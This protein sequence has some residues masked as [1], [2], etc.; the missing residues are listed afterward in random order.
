MIGLTAKLIGNAKG[1]DNRGLSFWLKPFLLQFNFGDG[2]DFAGNRSRYVYLD[3]FFFFEAIDELFGLGIAG[4]IKFVDLFVVGKHAVA[5]LNTLRHKQA[6]F[7][8]L[9][10]KA[11]FLAFVVRASDVYQITL[12]L[13]WGGKCTERHGG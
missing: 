9:G 4:F 10:A 6:I 2:H 7:G 5:A 8:V 3:V 11:R 1:R 12:D 13:G